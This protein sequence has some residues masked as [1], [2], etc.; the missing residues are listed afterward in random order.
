[1]RHEFRSAHEQI[2]IPAGVP[3]ANA[4]VHK[5]KCGETGYI[6]IRRSQSNGYTNGSPS[7]PS[8]VSTERHKNCY[9]LQ[10]IFASI[11]VVIHCLRALPVPA[12]PPPRAW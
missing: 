10:S 6:L 7:I 3:D 5:L 12:S 11:T 2:Y 1:M 9:S 4:D 8:V